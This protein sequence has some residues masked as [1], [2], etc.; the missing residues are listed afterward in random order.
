M[1]IPPWRTKEDATQVANCFPDAARRIKEIENLLLTNPSSSQVRDSI[2]SDVLCLHTALNRFATLRNA[3]S[4]LLRI[5]PEVLAQITDILLDIWPPLSWKCTRGVVVHLGWITL[6]HVCRQLRDV[7]LGRKELWAQ[8]IYRLPR[9]RD[10]MLERAGNVPISLRLTQAVIKSEDVDF[11]IDHLPTARAVEI[12]ERLW[13]PTVD[14][15]LEPAVFSQR[16]FPSLETLV[17]S[18]AKREEQ[19]ALLTVDVWELPP[20]I[21]PLL[22]TLRLACMA[23]PFN[24]TTLTTLN[25]SFDETPPQLYSSEYF[26]NMLRQCKLLQELELSHAS[27]PCALKPSEEYQPVELMSLERL[28]LEDDIN[29]CIGVWN[30]ITVSP[31]CTDLF[32][33]HKIENHYPD[34]CSYLRVVPSHFG[35]AFAV[36]IVGLSVWDSPYLDHEDP[37]SVGLIDATACWHVSDPGKENSNWTGPFKRDFKER[38]SLYLYSVNGVEPHLIEL[39]AEAIKSV[40]AS[41]IQVLE[42]GSL[43][44]Y[45]SARWATALAPFINVHTLYLENM[46]QTPLLSSL[47]TT[48]IGHQEPALL[49][50]PNLRFLWLQILEFGDTEGETTSHGQ[51]R[52]QFVRMLASR[53]QDGRPIEHIRIEE[54]RMDTMLAEK[55][56][57]PRLRAI[58]PLVECNT[59]YVPVFLGSN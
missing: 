43:R 53:K 8:S 26:L 41:Q 14:Y 55:S 4:P 57:L 42:I 13:K 36:P 58:V 9:A 48:K 19:M 47:S 12:G 50:L 45:T 59:I 38:L 7:L 46:P 56:F 30:H 22:K 11:V 6:S 10:C 1:L 24:P 34:F 29:T 18:L 54:L 44:P 28:L 32:H 31:S 33:L 37:E 40:D 49:T 21:T 25:I 52:V 39:L 17:L 3:C 2:E 15:T 20:P 51:D 5:P 35:S 23:L 27:P 16:S